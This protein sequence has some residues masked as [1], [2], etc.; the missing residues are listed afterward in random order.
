MTALLDVREMTHAFGGLVAVDGLSFSVEQ[1]QI[2]S[3]IGP[4]GAGKTTVFNCITGIYR[5]RKG[6]I[7]FGDRKIQGKPPHQIAQMGLVRTFQ[8]LRLFPNMTAMDNV[9]AGRHCRTRSGVL[10]AVLRGPWQQR[11]E[12]ESR[13]KAEELLEFVGLTA[14]KVHLAA[15]LS[16]GDQR[17]LE[18]ARAL[19]TEPKLLVLDE[20]AAGMNPGEKTELGDLIYRIR[21]RGVTVLLIEHDMRLVMRISDI[22]TVLNYGRKIFQGGPREVQQDPTVIEA[23]LGTEEE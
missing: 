2:A 21:E 20:P 15:Q 19:A 5:A 17:R 22:V 18:I 6:T 8:S 4:N 3:L 23:Y 7:T 12:R 16:Y 10:G 1:G 14:Q 11:E 9:L 13:V